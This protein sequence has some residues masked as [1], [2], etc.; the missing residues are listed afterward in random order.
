MMFIAIKINETLGTT[1]MHAFSDY[2]ASL[3]TNCATL[4][5]VRLNSYQVQIVSRQCCTQC[6]RTKWFVTW[7]LGV[8]MLKCGPFA[9]FEPSS[10]AAIQERSFHMTLHCVFVG[11]LVTQMRWNHIIYYRS[12]KKTFSIMGKRISLESTA[13]TQPTIMMADSS[14]HFHL[15]KE[16]YQQPHWTTEFVFTG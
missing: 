5:W 6:A 3:M 16:V 2:K 11:V 10:E 4:C 1:T 9:C 15:K 8:P 12:S 14:I 7:T 13:L